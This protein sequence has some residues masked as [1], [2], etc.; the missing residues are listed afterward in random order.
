ML[1]IIITHDSMRI[2]GHLDW[3][4]ELCTV[5][6]LCI[7]N[8]DYNEVDVTNASWIH[9]KYYQVSGLI[10]LGHSFYYYY[11]GILRDV[12][13]RSN[14]SITG[15]G[16]EAILQICSDHRIYIIIGYTLS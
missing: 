14:T 1:E 15:H 3:I 8:K 13:I 10:K 7:L 9:S 11:F 12:V 5:V 6:I 16:F 2:C 4:Y